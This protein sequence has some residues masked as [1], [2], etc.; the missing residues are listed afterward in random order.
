MICPCCW[1]YMVQLYCCICCVSDKVS[2][3]W[4]KTKFGSQN[5]GYQI[6][7]CT[8]LV[9]PVQQNICHLINITCFISRIL[10]IVH[11]LLWFQ[12]LWLCTGW[13]Y[14]YHSGLLQWHMGNMAGINVSKN[15]P[16]IQIS[17]PTMH[18][19]VIEMC[20]RVHISAT[21]WCTV[22]YLFV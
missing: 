1:G 8:R 4:Y 17:H 13:S 22:G 19:F 2:S 12:L 14:P 7:F 10:N 6:C 5:F 18:H 20:T 3:V 21:K 16:V 9:R 15:R 11:T